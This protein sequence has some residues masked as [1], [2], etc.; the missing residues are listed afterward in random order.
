MDI[1]PHWINIFTRDGHLKNIYT[2]NIKINNLNN[3]PQIK[4]SYETHSKAPVYRMVYDYD[5]DSNN[6]PQTTTFT[7][8]GSA[9]G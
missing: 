9:P 4:H 5:P 6:Q 2:F 1:N 7:R 3:K 8:W